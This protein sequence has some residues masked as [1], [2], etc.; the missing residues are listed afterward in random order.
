MF[1]THTRAHTHHTHT[2]HTHT[3]SRYWNRRARVYALPTGQHSRA[4]PA[5]LICSDSR[6]EKELGQSLS[7]MGLV[8][9]HKAQPLQQRCPVREGAAASF[10]ST[11]SPREQEVSVFSRSHAA[12]N[13][14]RARGRVKEHHHR[15]V[16]VTE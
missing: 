13:G 2:T 10:Q 12:R 14:T 7:R 16:R 5:S 1:D 11:S 8:K 9:G 6:K 15:L 4:T 3:Q